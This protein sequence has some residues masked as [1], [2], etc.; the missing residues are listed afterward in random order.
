MTVERRSRPSAALLLIPGLVQRW[1]EGPDRSG[2]ADAVRST[3]ALPVYADIGATLFVGPDGEVL[4]RHHDSDDLPQVEPDARL[5]LIALVWAVKKHPELNALLPERP[6]GAA[7]CGECGCTG[8]HQ[9]DRFELL[10]P[11][12]HGMGWLG[13]VV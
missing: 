9:L 6:V 4:N 7:D 8:A 1:L 13:A 11:K 12:C 10:C 2:V 3:G 5:R